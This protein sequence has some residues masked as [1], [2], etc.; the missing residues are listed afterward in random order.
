MLFALICIDR[1]NGL[2]LRLK[3]RAAHLKFLES[4]GV[5]MLS[6]GPIIGSDGNPIGSLVIIRA[7]DRTEAEKV[8]REDPYAIAGLFE[9]VEVLNWRPAL[10]QFAGSG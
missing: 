9:S 3:T 8:S 5:H 2:N 4:L 1:T 6:A 10:G 7:S